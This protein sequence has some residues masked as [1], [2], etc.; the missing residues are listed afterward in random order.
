MSRARLERRGELQGRQGRTC[1]AADRPHRRDRAAD[2]GAAGRAHRLHDAIAKSAAKLSEACAVATPG[3]PVG[4]LD[5][6]Q[7]RLEAMI[8][9]AQ[10][11]RPALEEFYAALDDEQKAKFNRLGR[12]SAQSRN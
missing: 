10:D 1:G 12:V 3:T 2:A 4:R 8:A 7:Q 5:T 11:I 6:M 9:A